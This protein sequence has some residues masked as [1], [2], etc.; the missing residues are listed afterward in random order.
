MSI[1]TGLVHFSN[2]CYRKGFLAATDGN[3]SVRTKKNFII[4]SPS[5]LCKGK[6][7]LQHLVKADFKG[8]KLAGE[9]EISSEF[10]L[11]KFIYESRKDINAVIHTHH[12]VV[13]P[14]M[15]LKFGKIPLAEYGTPSTAEIAQSVA[16]FVKEYNA[17]LL[18]NHGLVAMG[19]DIEEAYY[20]TEKVERL[21]EIT[22]Y[23]KLLGGEKV[24]NKTQTKKL[25]SLKKH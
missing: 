8:K 16:K 11:H 5:N 6:I 3:L 18:A 12:K 2:L 24:L 20:V 13:F 7:K 9:G 4:I 14:E 22:F 19:K 1:K 23:A 10:K 15:Y 17:I 25:D 21:A